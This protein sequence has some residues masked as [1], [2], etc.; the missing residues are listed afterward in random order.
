[1]D[2]EGSLRF[3]SR[4]SPETLYKLSIQ[5]NPCISYTK[6]RS[7]LLRFVPKDRE[8]ASANKEVDDFVFVYVNVCVEQSDSEYTHVSPYPDSSSLFTVT[9][10]IA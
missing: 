2:R 1:M 5:C 4:P 3:A 6:Q 8:K 10:Y 9:V 7:Y